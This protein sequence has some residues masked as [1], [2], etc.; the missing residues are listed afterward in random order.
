MK[1]MFPKSTRQTVGIAVI[2]LG[3]LLVINSLA[4]RGVPIA[5][6]VAGAVQ[7]GI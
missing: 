4:K 5:T 6:Q 7:T 2:A 3:G 1:G